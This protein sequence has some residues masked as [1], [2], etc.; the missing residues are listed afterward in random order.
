VP[1]GNSNAFVASAWALRAQR[2]L[3][4]NSRGP[5]CFDFDFYVQVS[6]RGKKQIM[7]TGGLEGWAAQGSA[8][9]DRAAWTQ[10][11]LP[12]VVSTPAPHHT[13]PGP[14]RAPSV[15][16]PAPPPTM[17]LAAAQSRPGWACHQARAAVGA[18]C[19][20][21]P[22]PGAATQVGMAACLR[23]RAGTALCCWPP[24]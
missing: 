7:R 6:G 5:G 3:F 20:A 15:P 2:M 18:L 19:G 16:C 10:S 4:V 11:Q 13:S 24:V 21:R 14:G 12:S 8:V 1:Q 23:G 22:V 17:C 9:Q